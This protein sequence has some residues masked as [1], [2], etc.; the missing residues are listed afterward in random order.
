LQTHV[1][2]VIARSD[3][4]VDGSYAID[5]ESATDE[6]K[7]APCFALR[8]LEV[9]GGAGLRVL[10]L[11]A[12]PEDLV[13][14]VVDLPALERIVLPVGVGCKLHLAL[15]ATPALRIDGSVR[16]ID[17]RWPGS[18]R[19]VEL[20]AGWNTK[21]VALRPRV[22]RG[23]WIGAAAL[24]PK[25]V[26]FACTL[27]ERA[28]TVDLRRCAALVALVA[29]ELFFVQRTAK[30]VALATPHELLLRELSSQGRLLQSSAKS[31]LLAVVRALEEG[32]PLEGTLMVEFVRHWKNDPLPALEALAELP[33]EVSGAKLWQARQQLARAEEGG[34]RDPRSFW[35][36]SFPSDLADRGWL[37]DLRIWHRCLR[38]SE[39]ARAF[40]YDVL[41]KVSDPDHLAA[42][43]QACMDA[44]LSKEPDPGPMGSLSNIDFVS[45]LAE[46]LKFGLG[47]G[48]YFRLQKESKSFEVQTVSGQH[49]VE[50][51]PAQ[52]N[53]RDLSAMT[54]VLRML[55]R[56]RRKPEVQALRGPFIAWILARMP[57]GSGVQTLGTMHRLGSNEALTAL[58]KLIASDDLEAPVCSLALTASLA[59]RESDFLA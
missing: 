47:E 4:G 2:Y 22:L 9:R 43:A 58:S 36:W 20:N 27:G 41:R 51:D 40:E 16:W 55:V 30:D 17:A 53:Q 35:S 49:W 39:A 18:K 48:Y 29:E 23:A 37:A 7:F 8:T 38:T 5:V 56:L 12:L 10:D 1:E 32:Q 54:I 13:V 11:S 6:L 52:T 33:P 26:Q 19:D 46:Q 28:K 59:P 31:T 44:Q 21:S 14:H 3:I 57:N 45:I 50:T 42:I 15:S 25:D 34:R 24:V